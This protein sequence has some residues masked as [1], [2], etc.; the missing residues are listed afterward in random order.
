MVNWWEST[1]DTMYVD[2]PRYGL[3]K[4]DWYKIEPVTRQKM[5]NLEKKPLY[6][7]RHNYISGMIRAKAHDICFVGGSFL[8]GADDVSAYLTLFTEISPMQALTITV[9][10]AAPVDRTTFGISGEAG[11]FSSS[12]LGYLQL[13]SVSVK[14]K[15]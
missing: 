15:F 8:F 11:E 14:V 9:T 6:Y 7:L 3:Q 12:T 1:G 2:N 13:W 5:F 10:M 4:E